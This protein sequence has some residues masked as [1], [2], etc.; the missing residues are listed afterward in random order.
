M[1]LGGMAGQISELCNKHYITST[2]ILSSFSDAP[3]WFIREAKLLE[4][5]RS[6]EKVTYFYNLQQEYT[7]YNGYSDDYY[8]DPQEQ[9]YFQTEM[10]RMMKMITKTCMK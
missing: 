6:W 2:A 7:S 9:Y 1:A 10:S 3:K 8:F 5:T 4:N